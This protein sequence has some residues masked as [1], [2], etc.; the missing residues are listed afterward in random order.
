MQEFNFAVKARKDLNLCQHRN[1]YNLACFVL[2]QALSEFKA[3]IPWNTEN[4]GRVNE[5]CPAGE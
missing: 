3:C 1:G 5:M 2:M 4:A